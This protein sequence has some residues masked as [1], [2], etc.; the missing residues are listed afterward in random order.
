MKSQVEV[1]TANC[2]VCDPVVKMIEEL[3]CDGCE[4]TTY[5]LVKKCD[6]KTCLTKMN[7][8]GVQKIPAIAVNGKLLDC[9]KDSA[10]TKE[11]LIEAGI[12]QN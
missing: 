10:I 11:K 2:P 7:E 9:C 6:D 3:T 8:Y 5:D 1:F 4:V 12:G